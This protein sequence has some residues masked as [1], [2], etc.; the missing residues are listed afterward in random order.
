M[1]D[2]NIDFLQLLKDCVA[3]LRAAAMSER[4]HPN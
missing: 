4:V 1:S 3:G 2:P